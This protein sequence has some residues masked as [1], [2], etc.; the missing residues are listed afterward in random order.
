MS[1]LFPSLATLARALRGP[2]SF[3]KNDAEE[4]Y[5]LMP[6]LTQLLPLPQRVYLADEGATPL[7]GYPVLASA[8]M[9]A[10]RE[11]L[12]GYIRAEEEAQVASLT[13]QA[14]DAPELNAAWEAYRAHLAR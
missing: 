7:I 9:K 3:L 10:L 1:D 13:R 5:R 6:E 4:I 2:L 14:V 12:A 8:G 11:A